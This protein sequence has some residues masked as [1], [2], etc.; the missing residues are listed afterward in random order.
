[1]VETGARQ[2]P[3]SHGIGSSLRREFIQA[4][5]SNGNFIRLTKRCRDLMALPPLNAFRVFECVARLGQ[6]NTAAAELHVTPGAVSQQIRQL[7]DGLEV[8]LFRKMGRNLVLT[9]QGDMLAR[10]VRSSLAEITEMVHKIK[11]PHASLSKSDL[12]IAIPPVF[13]AAWFTSRL[14][15]FMNENAHIRLRVITAASFA[16]VDWRNTDVAIVF[17]SPPWPGFW[18]RSLYA[19]HTF[20]VCSPQLLR[21][22]QGIREPFD[23]RHHRLL[24]EGDLSHWRRWLQAAKVVHPGGNDLILDDFGII[25]QAARDGHGVALTDEI[26]SERD[27]DDGHLVQPL[28]LR[29]P[30]IHNYYYMCTEKKI[31]EP[32]VAHTFNWLSDQARRVSEKARSG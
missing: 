8:S 22:P 19:T 21:G 30:A 15:A 14:F 24:H 28:S 26:I 9:E 16:A 25:M 31:E 5:L 32:K 7:Q 20:P 12:T 13:G 1:M 29:Q 11:S 23:L 2:P 17:G 27:L 18:W 3:G 10:A 4:I 6:I